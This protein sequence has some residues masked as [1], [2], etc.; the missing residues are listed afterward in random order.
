[1][2]WNLL[3]ESKK[4]VLIWRNWVVV[5]N[6][7]KDFMPRPNLKGTSEIHWYILHHKN[8][9]S[10]KSDFS[11]ERRRMFWFWSWSCTPVF[12]WSLLPCSSCSQY[13]CGQTAVLRLHT[14]QDIPHAG[15]HLLMHYT[16]Q[17]I[18]QM[19]FLPQ[20]IREWKRG[21]CK[22]WFQGSVVTRVQVGRLRNWEEHES[23][24]L[25]ATNS[26]P[27]GKE[28]AHQKKKFWFCF[29]IFFTQGLFW[30]DHTK[31]M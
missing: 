20:R 4:G 2:I 1:M 13:W 7:P 21:S 26:H 31:M 14:I 16:S 6:S 25:L 11:L 17:L 18:F 23:L 12:V 27:G 30:Q 28:M 24:F 10:Q 15:C 19:I 8:S 9:T 3:W 22:S 29:A 5:S